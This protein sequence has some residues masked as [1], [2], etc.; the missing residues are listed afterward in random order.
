MFRKSKKWFKDNLVEILPEVKG[1]YKKDVPMSKYTW[2]A[3]GGP[4]EV[5][6]SP[7]DEKDLALD[8]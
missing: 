1:T 3:V 4:A 2:F 7:H 8:R 5:M 6:F